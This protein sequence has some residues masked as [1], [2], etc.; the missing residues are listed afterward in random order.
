MD[1]FTSTVS[2]TNVSASSTTSRFDTVKVTV[3]SCRRVTCICSSPCTC[4]FTAEL[5]Q[6]RCCCPIIVAAIS[7]TG[8]TVSSSSTTTTTIGCVGRCSWMAS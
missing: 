8:D 7:T 2:S 4:I 5:S 3:C 1:R 6:H